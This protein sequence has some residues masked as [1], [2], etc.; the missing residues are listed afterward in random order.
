MKTLFKLSSLLITATLLLSL[1]CKKKKNEPAPSNPLPP[2]NASEVITTFKL[3]L[4]DSATST[5][6]TFMYKD[7]DGDGGQAGFYGPG[8]SSLSTQ[9]D[10]VFNL[11]PNTTYFTEIVLL[12]ETKSP[13]DSIS[14][15]VEEEGQDHMFFFNS[16]NPTGSPYSLTLGGSGIHLIYTDLDGG[17][18]QRGIGLK[19][20][21]RTYAAT[22]TTK[23]PLNIILKHQPGTKNGTIT[24]G[25]T[26]VD[27]NFKMTVQ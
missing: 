17:S 4:T 8:T 6:Y 20:R 22:G 24:P 26:D 9:S 12:D 23:H 13:V 18:P 21:W 3:L 27:V 14:N 5:V 10:S 11:S 1:S 16:T 15:E 2:D 25:D 7:P 19:T